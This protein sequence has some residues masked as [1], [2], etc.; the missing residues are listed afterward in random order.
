MS[1]I[2][3]LIGNINL[4][5]RFISS[6]FFCLTAF[7]ICPPFVPTAFIPNQ[8]C[9]FVKYRGIFFYL[10]EMIIRGGRWYIRVSKLFSVDRGD[11]E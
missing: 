3:L 5:Y 4:F 11:D 8:A 9:G 6:E 1:F 10:G 7:T 2:G